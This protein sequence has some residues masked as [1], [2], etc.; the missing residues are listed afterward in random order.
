MF[1]ANAMIPSL[2]LSFSTPLLP[3]IERGD[4]SVDYLTEADIAARFG[5]DFRGEEALGWVL[6]RLAE[7]GPSLIVL[8]R[9][10][11]PHAARI[12]DW[13]D[14]NRVPTIFHVDDDLLNIPIELGEKKFRAHNQPERLEAVRHLLRNTTLTYCSTH[15]LGRRFFGD[16]PPDRVVSGEVYCAHE[17]IAPPTT[18]HGPVVGYMGFDHAHDFQIVLPALVR[19]LDARPGL[20]FE[21]FG[22]IPVPPEL[23]RFGDRIRTI[24]PVRDYAAFVRKL[25]SLRWTIGICPLAKTPFNE[26]KADTKWVE[27][28]ACGFAVIAS[29]G[30]IYDRC[31]AD[32]C[33]LLVDGEDE[34][35]R[36]FE[37]LL[38]DQ[39]A[40]RA[41]V[42]RAQDRLRRDYSPQQLLRQIETVFARAHA[43]EAQ[44]VATE[45]DA[46]PVRTNL[47]EVMGPD[48]KGWAWESEARSGGAAP[49]EIRCG[50]VRLGW[51]ERRVPR[52]DV[53]DHVGHWGRDKGFMMP[54]GCLGVLYRFMHRPP[55]L[56]PRLLFAGEDYSLHDYSPKLNTL[57]AFRTLRAADGVRG[58]HVADLWWAGGHLLKIRTLAVPEDLPAPRP[59]VLRAYQPLRNPAGEMVLTQVEETA[60]SAKAGILAVGVRSPL[61]PLLLVGCGEDGEIAFAD[62]VPF[63]SLL[64]GGLHEA[65]AAALGEVGSGLDDL[66]RLSDTYLAELIGVGD[67][68]PPFAL[69]AVEVDLASATGTEPLFD[70]MV[71]DWLAAVPGVPVVP[72]RAEERV[73]RDLGDRG[74][75]DYA[76]ARLTEAR[77]P[78]AREAEARLSLPDAAAIPTIAALVARRAAFPAG[79]SIAPHIVV[80][81]VS[82]SRRWFVSIPDCAPLSR[83]P[84][85]SALARDGFPV[86][87]GTGDTAPDGR[88]LPL[89]ILFRDLAPQGDAALT[90]PV[91]ADHADILPNPAGTPGPDVS[92]IVMVEA[93]EPNL[94]SLLTAIAGQATAR[95]PEVIVGVAVPE[96]SATATRNLL[97]ELCP[98]RSRLVA[99]LNGL[100]AGEMLNRAAAQATGEVLVVLD[101]GVILHDHRTLDTLA[102]LALAEGAGTVGCLQ[103]R[104][105]KP[106]DKAL[107]AAAAGL[108]PGCFDA[109]A[110]P[111][112]GLVEPACDAILPVTVY[113]V[114]ANSP[115]CFAVATGL[116]R[117]AGGM[118]PHCWSRAHAAADLAVRLAEA[119]RASLCTTRLSVHVGQAAPARAPDVYTAT[120]VGPWRLLPAIR[121]STLLRS[122]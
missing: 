65:E 29:R 21:M 36:A 120:Q 35:L 75:A 79:A 62:L 10:S 100:D 64:R 67:R 76:M 50:D 46:P 55:G 89:A 18:D 97:A 91:P 49:L 43:L 77:P 56:H 101:P 114:A 13:A 17:V 38:D 34:W 37:T 85:L 105:R 14:R 66:R 40:H 33:G 8:C 78:F 111:S 42:G 60:L 7:F 104:P 87:T 116:W 81:P 31:C 69:A 22:S 70:P 71:R 1:V 93:G 52:L 112:L 23:G 24:E 48:V 118:N 20:A 117:E 102:R 95:P 86:V 44:N 28:T 83:D 4:L 115:H 84:A 82:P 106:G 12:V 39:A 61:M 25:A 108:F 122:F 5:R 30:T 26:V 113:P 53:D 98:D 9:Y 59:V 92:V 99:D 110:T 27:Y 58:L 19:L 3:R 96:W 47:E 68:P 119:G 94:R 73:A 15:A 63:P 107:A 80:D 32:G 45:R 51:C 88:M 11:G 57:S 6:G 90:F 74:F 109:A 2:Q 16:A 54:V 121:A 103:V 41:Q 72:I